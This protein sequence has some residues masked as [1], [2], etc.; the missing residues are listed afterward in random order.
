MSTQELQVDNDFAS[1]IPPLNKDE[2]SHLEQSILHEGCR[3][4]IITWNGII[5]DGHHRFKICKEHNV[6]FKTVHKEFASRDEVF[7]W[8]LNNQLAR[9]NLNA[10][11]RIEMARNYERAVKAQAKARQGT[12]NDIKQLSGNFSGMSLPTGRDARDEL[13]AMAGVSGNTYQHAIYVLNNAPVPIIEAARNNSIS[14]NAAYEL[15]KMTQ[16]QQT[17]ALRRIEQG[18]SAKS[19]ISQIKSRDQK[20]QPDTTTANSAD[21]VQP[22]S[23]ASET[24]FH[25]EDVNS[26]HEANSAT[27]N[28]DKQPKEVPTPSEAQT[29]LKETPV[30]L[31]KADATNQVTSDTKEHE[32]QQQPQVS[33]KAKDDTTDKT[34]LQPTIVATSSN[35]PDTYYKNELE[36]EPDEP[37]IVNIHI[38]SK[39]YSIIYAEPSWT[40]NQSFEELLK[41][42]VQRIAD[43][44]CALFLWVN[45]PRLPEA[46]KLS[47]Q[48]G[49]SRYETVPFVWSKITKNNEGK[50]I[51]DYDETSKW[52][53]ENAEFCI[54]ATKGTIQPSQNDIP[55]LTAN[56]SEQSNIKPDYFKEMIIQLLGELPAI[57]LFPEADRLDY[58]MNFHNELY[59]NH[60][61]WDMAASREYLAKLAKE[62]RAEIH[63]TKY[64]M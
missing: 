39:K 50:T 13:G 54:V 43:K 2:Y 5:V 27:M 62:R 1:L 3:D 59:G 30:P 34:T 29:P 26:Q 53:R 16:T 9:R 17:E 37:T 35:E 32:I 23:A 55:Q 56:Y 14:I 42:P 4:P 8:I 49:F 58:V 64:D 41:L 45:A 46:Q 57:E 60:S 24:S 12:R 31:Q 21:D 7:L 10:F 19:V 51:T 33:S 44:N 25:N 48:W 38:T 11:R 22:Q 47:E 61:P 20:S 6:P 28:E 15:T 40:D 63:N 18:E 36:I 52:T